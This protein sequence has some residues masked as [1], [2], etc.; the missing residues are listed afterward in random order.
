MDKP[1][2]HTPQVRFQIRL[3]LLSLD[4][5]TFLSLL[6]IS[7]LEVEGVVRLLIH[8]TPTG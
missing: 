8:T 2:L 5:A 1:L 7:L 3:A 6:Y 4:L